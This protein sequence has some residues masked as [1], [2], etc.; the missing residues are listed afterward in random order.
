MAGTFTYH[1]GVAAQKYEHKSTFIVIAGKIDTGK[2]RIAKALEEAL[3][4]LGKNVYFL[5][6]SIG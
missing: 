6:I 2:Q 4:N 3:F 1:S 5:G